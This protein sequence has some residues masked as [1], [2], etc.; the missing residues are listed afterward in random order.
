MRK[1]YIVAPVLTLMLFGTMILFTNS[2]KTV[3]AIHC[4]DC[5][6]ET[7]LCIEGKI[8]NSEVWMLSPEVGDAD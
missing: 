1:V 3:E 4:K 5:P 2:S 6:S 7:C 8:D